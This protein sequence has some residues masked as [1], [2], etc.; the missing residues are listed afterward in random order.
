[1][2]KLTKEDTKRIIALLKKH[3]KTAYIQSLYPQV[4]ARRIR[5]I[6]E[7]NKIGD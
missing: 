3:I 1:M 6:R 7:E 2:K 5:Q 4:S